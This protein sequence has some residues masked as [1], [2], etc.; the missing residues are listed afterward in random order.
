MKFGRHILLCMCSVLLVAAGCESAGK[1]SND[2]GL[3]AYHA[4]NYEKAIGLFRQAITQDAD[5]AEYYINLGMAQCQTGQ[6]EA[7]EESFLTAIEYNSRS[8]NAYRGLG[9]ACMELERYKDALD[10]FDRAFSNIRKKNSEQACDVIAY[11]AEVRMRAHDYEGAI[12]DYQTLIDKG[13][14][15]EQMYIYLGDVYLR[16]R[17][18]VSALTSYQKS[19]NMDHRD[20][21]KYLNMIKELK[22]Q[23]FEE[24]SQIVQDAALSIVPQDAE[25]R[26]YRGLIYLEQ[27]QVR[28]AFAEFEQS[29]NM[30]YEKSGYCLGYCYEL[31]GEYEEAELV[32]QKQ[33]IG[34]AEE[35]ARLYNQLAACKIRQQKFDEA[36][37][38][39]EQGFSLS[40]ETVNADLLW[41]KA[42]C[43]E[44]K[45]DYDTAID[46]L[47]EYHK[48]FP[49]D[50]NCTMELS[51]LRS[52]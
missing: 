41:N 46:I 3:A 22:I 48:Q 5:R 19:I 17:D 31:R 45:R 7:A 35:E 1:A 40:D 47:E 12:A 43:Y 9:I 8:V 16:Q 26:Y 6:Y 50:E 49:D 13:Y 51:Y 4:G 15:T 52:R 20:F 33:L 18:T 11:R 44:G 21:E 38:M 28:E 39:I 34:A 10:A 32:Y 30:G 25:E 37:L 24:E 29:Y 2:Q 23:G 42:M 36:L 14:E 27:E